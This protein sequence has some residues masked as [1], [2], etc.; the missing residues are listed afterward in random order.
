M[1]IASCLIDT[2]I[3]L[4]IA[5]RS[6]PHHQFVDT[7]LARL[8]EK[9]QFYTEIVSGTA[10]SDPRCHRAERRR[11]CHH[12]ASASVPYFTHNLVHQPKFGPL[13]FLG[14]EIALCGRG[15]AALRTEGRFS[16]GT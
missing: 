12:R 16:S 5:R 2:N 15:E 6:D 13:I 1:A 9:V 3:L 8:R 14:D 11:N 7:A 10:R 4:R